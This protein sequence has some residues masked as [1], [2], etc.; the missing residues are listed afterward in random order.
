MVLPSHAGA[1]SPRE[2]IMALKDK[3]LS[4]FE[5]VRTITIRDAVIEYGISGGTF[6]KI[7]SEL[8]REQYRIVR[9]WKKSPTG[10]RYACY[11]LVERW[12][13][14]PQDDNRQGKLAV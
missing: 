14:W 5:M 3:I 6:T 8:R 9:T 4:H 2:N 10:T 13:D 11:T 7:I 12:A 1:K